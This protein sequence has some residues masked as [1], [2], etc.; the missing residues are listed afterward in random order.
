[1]YKNLAEAIESAKEKGYIHLF[2]VGEN[3]LTCNE[4]DRE[5]SSDSLQI[6]ASFHFDRGTNPGDDASLYLIETDTGAKGYIVTGYTTYTNR[7]K[8]EF[9]DKLLG[10]T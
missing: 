8:A 1:M 5:F 2:E 4:L 3:S 9:L 10:E 6:A 7:T